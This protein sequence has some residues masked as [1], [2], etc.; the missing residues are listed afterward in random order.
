[1]RLMQNLQPARGGTALYARVHYES[2]A[3][4]KRPLPGIVA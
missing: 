3:S 2:N 4:A 1:M